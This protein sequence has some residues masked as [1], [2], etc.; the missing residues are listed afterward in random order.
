[1]LDRIE[2]VEDCGVCSLPAAQLLEYQSLR[3][4]SVVATGLAYRHF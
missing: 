1:M 3:R 4:I 2:G